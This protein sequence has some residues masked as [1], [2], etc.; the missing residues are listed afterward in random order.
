MQHQK[1]TVEELNKQEFWDIELLQKLYDIMLDDDHTI[2]A[3][4]SLPYVFRL[5]VPFQNY[6]RK[7]VQQEKDHY[8]NDQGWSEEQLTKHLAPPN[9][10]GTLDVCLQLEILGTN[11][12]PPNDDDYRSVANLL[13]L[14]GFELVWKL[15]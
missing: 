3:C 1:V 6:S 4:Q 12:K 14:V 7:R 2:V 13:V 10:V 15:D 9:M 8:F 5:L 11:K